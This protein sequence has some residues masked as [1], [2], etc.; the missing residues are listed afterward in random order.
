MSVRVTVQVLDFHS[1]MFFFGLACG[2][3]GLYS[4]H[5]PSSAQEVAGTT[6]KLLVRDLL[7]EARRSIRSLSSAAGL[8][9]VVL[10]QSW[11]VGPR[12]RGARRG[13]VRALP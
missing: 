5:R 8:L 11:L 10:P 9:R 12:S 13:Q 3:A 7:L 4:L 6:D 1:W 2:A